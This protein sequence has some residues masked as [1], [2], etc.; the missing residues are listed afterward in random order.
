MQHSTFFY[1]NMSTS[2][3]M[4]TNM[5]VMFFLVLSSIHSFLPFSSVFANLHISSLHLYIYISMCIFFIFALS[6]FL[7][8][9]IYV[10]PI[11]VS[12]S[13]IFLS[14]NS[15]FVFFVCKFASFFSMS[16]CLLSIVFA[17]LFFS[18]LHPPF[19]FCVCKFIFL[20]SV[21]LRLS[22]IICCLCVS[23]F[24]SL[25]ICVCVLIHSNIFL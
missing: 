4:N 9:Q 19:F 14:L 3:I 1:V 25:H 7:C 8:L 22:C 13:V 16:L 6:L 10:F 12:M 5:L 20:L 17:C 23:F 11:C 15:P 18:S 24:S 21:S 2:T